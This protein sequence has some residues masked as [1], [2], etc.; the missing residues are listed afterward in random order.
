MLKA[1]KEAGASEAMFVMLRLPLEIRD[2]FQEWLADSRPDRARRVM[3]LI[4]Q[5]R[6]GRDNDPRFGARMKGE[7]PVAQLIA[8]R[9]AAACK[10]YG[11]NRERYAQDESLFRV[12][13]RA[14]DQTDLFA[15]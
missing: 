7:G 8:A 11:L 2:L 3:S 14:G 15:A 5:V 4:R 6:G 10:R 9:F 1:A 13:P 12:P